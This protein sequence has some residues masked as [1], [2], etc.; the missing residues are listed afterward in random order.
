MRGI[1]A[2][3][4]ALRSAVTA[5]VSWAGSQTAGLSG[6][7]GA[8]RWMRL[9]AGPGGKA[10]RRHDRAEGRM[11]ADLG[12]L[13]DQAWPGHT[14]DARAADCGDVIAPVPSA[15]AELYGQ[16]SAG[17]V[18]AGRHAAMPWLA[19]RLAA[20][21]AAARPW[22][23]SRVGVPGRTGPKNMSTCESPPLCVV[24]GGRGRSC[25]GPDGHFCGRQPGEPGRWPWR[26]VACRRFAGPCRPQAA[27]AGAHA[28]GRQC[29][30]RPGGAGLGLD[31]HDDLGPVPIRGKSLAPRRR[32]ACAG[33]G[34]HR[35]P[36]DHR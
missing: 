24:D 21:G 9:L 19:Q 1:V 7:G 26:S 15:A 18:R 11:P 27:C 13:R 16:P 22:P 36:Q 35:R 4:P 3:S 32:P 20:P 30:E 5:V 34:H 10:P 33:S 8:A 29:P 14:S 28:P 6:S 25:P 2:W 17:A 31:G 12:P 23:A